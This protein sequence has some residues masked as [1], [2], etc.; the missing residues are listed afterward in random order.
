MALL[1]SHEVKIRREPLGGGGG[2]LVTIKGESIFF[3]DAEAL[4]AE[5]AA[6]CAEAVVTLL[7][8]DTVYLR[9]EVR[10]YVENATN[11]A[12]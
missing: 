12:P 10:R 1:E 4:T 9:P 11:P 5:V 8:I 3:I 6:R 2:G 7:D